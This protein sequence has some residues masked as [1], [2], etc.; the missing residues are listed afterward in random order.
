MGAGHPGARRPQQHHPLCHQAGTQC[1]VVHDGES[2]DG[3]EDFG[4]LPRQPCVASWAVANC[5][6]LREEA[7]K[8]SVRSSRYELAAAEV[9]RFDAMLPN[10]LKDDPSDGGA[11]AGEG[12]GGGVDAVEGPG[13]AADPAP[14]PPGADAP[15]ADDSDEGEEG[16]A[17]GPGGNKC[18]ATMLATLKQL[19][20]AKHGKRLGPS[21]AHGFVVTWRNHSDDRALFDEWEMFLVCDSY[22]NQLWAT[23][24]SEV[25]SGDEHLCVVNLPLK[26]RPLWTVLDSWHQR[27]LEARSCR[28]AYGDWNGP[29]V[30]I[31]CVALKRDR[32]RTHGAQAA[33]IIDD[34]LGGVYEFGMSV[35][36]DQ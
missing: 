2:S 6:A 9:A 14:S 3:A 7:K 28:V 16:E 22:K 36:R 1:E 32:I 30:D 27:L 35:G 4:G 8:F 23:E 13:P 26:H 18:A 10:F 17:V 24:A 25:V 5:V 31:A 15:A 19:F 21:F 34:E 20:A 29:D 33:T 12:G 11:D